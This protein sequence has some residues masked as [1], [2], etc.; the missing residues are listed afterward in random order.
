M[1]PSREHRL[2]FR[3]AVGDPVDASEFA[4]VRWG[5]LMQVLVH[6][7]LAAMVEAPEAS[8]DWFKAGAASIRR[9]ILA[10][11]VL[12][13]HHA[14]RIFAALGRSGIRAVPMKGY[15]LVREVYPAPGLRDMTDID[16]LVKREEVPAAA[17]ALNL[18]GWTPPNGAEIHRVPERSGSINAM[19]FHA[20]DGPGGL[21]HAVHLHWDV[22]NSTLP[23]GLALPP[24]PM[25]EIRREA[26]AVEDGILLMDRAHLAVLVAEHAFKHSFHDLVSLADLVRVMRGVEGAAVEATARRWGLELPVTAALKL[27]AALRAVPSPPVRGV[28]GLDGRWFLRSVLEG[29]RWNGLSGLG[30]LSMM[31]GL[32]GRARFLRALFFP[33]GGAVRAYGRRPGL[34]ETWRR[35]RRAWGMVTSG[36]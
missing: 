14:G 10:R 32:R 36:N 33:E 6:E 22:F 19:L 17:A 25:E 13:G 26:R 7:R 12:L 28:R 15:V 20:P 21:M 24:I 18:L 4:A 8:P 11:H 30:Y 35:C 31:P 29:R 3:M 9:T 16:I 23:V 27:A 5:R 2:A 34:G 1:N